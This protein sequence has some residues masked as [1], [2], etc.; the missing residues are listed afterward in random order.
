VRRKGFREKYITE[1]IKIIVRDVK[2]TNN[3]IKI[4]E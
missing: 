4:D 1:N 3:D 2:K